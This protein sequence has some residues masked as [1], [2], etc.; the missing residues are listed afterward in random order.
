M[1]IATLVVDDLA[2]LGFS[3]VEN[4]LRQIERRLGNTSFQRFLAEGESEPYTH[5]WR[6]KSA[7]W[8]IKH[9]VK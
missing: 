9:E 2:Y 7:Y 5:N 4:L 1:G 8:H 6:Q 3:G